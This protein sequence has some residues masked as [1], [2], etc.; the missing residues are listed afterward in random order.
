MLCENK[1]ADKNAGSIKRVK[2]I[3]NAFTAVHKANRKAIEDVQTLSETLDIDISQKIASRLTKDVAVDF[4]RAVKAAM[5]KKT[6]FEAVGAREFVW[7][8]LKRMKSDHGM[9][10]LAYLCKVLRLLGRY[11][12]CKTHR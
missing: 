5:K 7:N 8:A 4:P 6:K 12:Q 1:S 10:F 9:Y 11:L 3:V 2:P